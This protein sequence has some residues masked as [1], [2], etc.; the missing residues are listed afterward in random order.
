MTKNILDTILSDDEPVKKTSFVIDKKVEPEIKK[1]NVEEIKT[2]KVDFT[3]PKT[4]ELSTLEQT[5]PV[6]VAPP[7]KSNRIGKIYK[8][9]KPTQTEKTRTLTEEKVS[10]KRKREDETSVEISLPSEPLWLSVSEAA[11]IG[12]VEQK[13]IRRAIQ[14]EKVKFKIINDRYLIEF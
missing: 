8:K 3:L 14:S 13:T 11:K 1:E 10:K 2:P 7:I 6:V 4:E 9:H 12:G 5:A